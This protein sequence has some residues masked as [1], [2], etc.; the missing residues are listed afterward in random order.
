[1]TG[2]NFSSWYNTLEGTFV[3]SASTVST[4]ASKGVYAASDGTNSNRI[5]LSVTTEPNHLIVTSGGSPSEADITISSAISNNTV[6][7]DAFAYRQNDVNAATNGVL[8]TADPTAILPVVNQFR[9]GARGD[10][11]NI[12]SGHVRS[13]DYY[14]VRWADAQLPSLT[15]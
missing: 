14:P 11:S 13:L 3:V 9:I 8:G 4:A 7:R 12:I 10:G 2:T 6:F 15:I 1:M 5:Y